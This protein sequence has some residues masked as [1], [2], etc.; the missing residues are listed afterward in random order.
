MKKLT[1][2][3]L[4]Q[5]CVDNYQSY[6]EIYDEEDI[7]QE[8]NEINNASNMNELINILDGLGFNNNEAYEFIFNSI[9]ED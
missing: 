3:E 2:E 6:L 1:F 9:L 5:N 7:C 4:K 8:N